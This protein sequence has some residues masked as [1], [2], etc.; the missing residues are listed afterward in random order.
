M[1]GRDFTRWHTDILVGGHWL[2]D[3]LTVT[4]DFLVNGV[5]AL[6]QAREWYIWG[7]HGWKYMNIGN[8]F[9]QKQICPNGAIVY[10]KCYWK[11]LFQLLFKPKENSYVKYFAY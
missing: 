6:F 10:T 5:V 2:E 11:P 4:K 8:D 3:N 9:E 1:I 7:L